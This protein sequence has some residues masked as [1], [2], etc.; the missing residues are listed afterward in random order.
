MSGR[1]PIPKRPAGAHYGLHME[2]EDVQAPRFTEARRKSDTENARTIA[3]HRG[4]KFDEDDQLTDSSGDV[5]AYTIED[6]AAG[7]VSLGWITPRNWRTDWNSIPQDEQL[8]AA[9]LRATFNSDRKFPGRW[10]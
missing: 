5:I 2:L 6:A 9:A 4:W 3:A 1:G 8:A 10:V 7:M